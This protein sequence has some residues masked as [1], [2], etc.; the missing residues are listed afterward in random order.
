MET[1]DNIKEVEQSLLIPHVNCGMTKTEIKNCSEQLI[2]SVLEVGNV[3][4]VAEGLS[5]LTE[6]VKLIR[7]DERFVSYLRDELAKNKGKV[8]TTSGAKIEVAEVGTNYDFAVCADVE[9]ERLESEMNSISERLKARREFLKTVPAKGLIIT[10]EDS[11]ETYTVYPPAKTS[12]SS[13]KI[14]LAK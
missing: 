5:A 6:F 12:K 4:S 2:E 7:E 1:T 3:V 14:T 13:Y 10:D 11:G 9:Q 8:Q